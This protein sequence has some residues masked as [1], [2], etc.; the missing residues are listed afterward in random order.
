ME[1]KSVN[2]T[3][4]RPQP[5]FLLFRPGVAPRTQFVTGRTRPRLGFLGVGW[6]GRHRLE[7][8][9]RSG[10]AEIAAC[11]D[12]SSETLREV[13]SLAP[14]A[15]RLTTLQELLAQE[16][17]GIVIATPSA[18]HTEQALA[19]L[20]QGKAVF[21]QKPL[22]RSGAETREVIAAA[23]QRDRLLGVD[24]SYRHITGIRK[25]HELC[26][27]GALGEIYAAE[28]VFH[29][30]YGPDRAWF[31][32]KAQSGGGCVIDLGIHLVDLA[33]WNFGFPAVNG[34]SA[35]LFRQGR[36][37]RES[38][39]GVEDYASAQLE[40]ENGAALQLTCSWRLPAGC[41]AVIRGAFYGTKGGA[42]FR[43]LNG[44]FY[45]FKAERFE[46]TRRSV[47]AEAEEDWGGRAII[48]WATRLGAGCGFDSE[49]E[50][51]SLVASVLDRIYESAQRVSL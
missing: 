14:K 32:D 10:V 33:L 37:L 40:L 8:V 16:L 19:A 29:N 26:R 48:D 30:A 34:V 6:I 39:D 24:F 41:D 45:H 43:N 51:I 23:R 3:S 50:Q 2:N 7:A 27:S 28:L 46:G 15:S 1:T 36:P 11:A 17:D 42:A 5:S 12:L 49:A 18:L 9:A 31:Y 35:R 13:A 4:A 44:S 20:R 38:A 25:I 22:A 21:C 47:L